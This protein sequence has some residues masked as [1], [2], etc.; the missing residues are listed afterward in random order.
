MEAK[1]TT[2]T[3]RDN[4]RIIRQSQLDRAI[5]MC[6]LFEIKPTL[7]EV[8]RLSQLLTNFQYDWNLN[9]YE[10]VKF[11]QHFNQKTSD[12]ITEHIPHQQTAVTQPSSK[13]SSPYQLRNAKENK[14]RL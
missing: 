14:G 11:E 10:L 4:E 5:D 2:P 13:G 1:N 7:R 6:K 12:K 3:L 9:N 8:L